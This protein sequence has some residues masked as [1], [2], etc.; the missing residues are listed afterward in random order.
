MTIEICLI[1]WK[2]KKCDFILMQSTNLDQ[3]QLM[4]LVLMQIACW[5][6][7]S[8]GENMESNTL[9]MILDVCDKRREN[10]A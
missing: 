1:I 7:M 2:L 4:V 9:W 10:L 5:L 8:S 6:T 3:F